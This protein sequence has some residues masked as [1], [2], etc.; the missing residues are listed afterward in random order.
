[1]DLT[2]SELIKRYL[3]GDEKSL[4]ILVKRYLNPL[5]V[6]LYRY[7][8]N[9]E[10]A[11]N[12]TQDSFVKTW[13]NLKKFDRS[14]SFKTWLFSIAKNTATDFLRKKKN[15]SFSGFEK[16]DGVDNFIDPAPLPQ[17]IFERKELNKILNSAIKKL[18]LD[19]QTVL[20]LRYNDHFTFK[21]ISD[22]LGEPVNTVKSRH[23][24]AL[25]LLRNLI[26]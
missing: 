7:V 15:I 24:R 20:F 18:S 6:F 19:N 12:I 11:E 3:S 1:M 21:E 2:D 14:K 23:R 25:I 13:R 22:I 8:G 4:E 5:Y 16:E 10:D 17:E 26:S 9:K